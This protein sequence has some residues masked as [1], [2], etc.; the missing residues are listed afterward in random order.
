MPFCG[1]ASSAS[2]TRARYRTL[3]VSAFSMAFAIDTR[4]H[5]QSVTAHSTQPTATAPVAAGAA[6]ADPVTVALFSGDTKARIA[7]ENKILAAGA[8]SIP[9]LLSAQKGQRSR[10]LATRLITKMGGAVAVPALL[11]LLDDPN[12][13][14]KAGSNLFLVIGAESAS[15]TPALMDCVRGKPDV[16]HYCGTSLMKAMSPKAASQI[17]FLRRS[18]MDADQD[19]RVYALGALGQ[20][21]APAVAAAPDMAKALTDKA[22]EVRLAA[23][24]ALG[25]LRGTSLAVRK[26]LQAMAAADPSEEVRA[27]AKKALRRWHA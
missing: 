1:C 9:G 4:A 25:K 27:L 8:A 23:V 12:L 17:P 10:S 5:A 6:D 24:V 18:L 22:P 19:V 2:H 26:A 7:A 15:R 21:G 14:Q 3:I 11:G 16:K 20:V 13:A